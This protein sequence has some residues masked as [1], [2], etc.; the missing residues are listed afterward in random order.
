L[1]QNASMPVTARA[2]TVSDATAE[3]ALHDHARFARNS[4]SELTALSRNLPLPETVRL[5]NKTS[6]AL[7]VMSAFTNDLSTWA[8]PVHLSGRFGATLGRAA[9]ERVALSGA[10]SAMIAAD[11][12]QSTSSKTEQPPTQIERFER[13]LGEWKGLLAPDHFEAIAW[14]IQRMLSDQEELDEDNVAPS[15]SSFDDMLA[16]LSSRPWDRPPAVGMSKNGQFSAS[17]AGPSPHRDVTLTFLGEGLIKW[18]VYGLGRKS[19]GS[20]TGSCDRY[21]L[22]GLLTRLGCDSWMAR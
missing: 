8:A 5:Q 15:L 12:G 10:C 22:P 20:A 14:H 19:A 16:F 17:W 3:H 18:Y 4:L 6:L 9:F 11:A 7:A 1:T 2:T 21:D 13:A